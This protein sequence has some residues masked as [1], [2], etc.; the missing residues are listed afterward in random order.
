MVDIV[1]YKDDLVRIVQVYKTEFD[2]DGWECKVDS[3]MENHS[4]NDGFHK[5]VVNMNNL[6]VYKNLEILKKTYDDD[7][8]DK[9]N[10]S[11]D[12]P[13]IVFFFL[14]DNYIS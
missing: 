8:E 5:F 3:D 7:L 11:N 12:A 4:C 1:V 14:L 2:L 10:R 13:K 6:V 9:E